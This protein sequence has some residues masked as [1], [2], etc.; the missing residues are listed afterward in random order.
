MS[1]PVLVGRARTPIGKLLG[2]LAARPTPGLGGIA[3]EAA[4]QRAGIAGDQVDALILRVRPG[5]IS[6]A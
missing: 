6:F 3:V 2:S 5:M 4:Q 1:Q